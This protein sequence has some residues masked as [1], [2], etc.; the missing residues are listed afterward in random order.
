MWYYALSSLLW[1]FWR[2]PFL[3][4]L[5]LALA[6]LLIDRRYIGLLPDLTRPFRHRRH[7]ARLAE[8]IRL[9]PADAGSQLELG[10]LHLERGEVRQ[11]LPLLEQALLRME[12]S[13]R[14]HSLLGIAY[15]RL[16]RLPEAR[17]ALERAVAL[18]PKVGYGTPYLHL[19]TLHLRDQPRDETVLSEIQ[20]RILT[21]GSPEVFY[22]AGRALLTGGDRTGARVMFQEAIENYQASPKGFRRAHR[23]WALASR[24][25]LR[26]RGM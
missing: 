23:R 24:A 19:L 12:D 18:N 15:H 5:F 17:Q 4:L 8:I 22:R 6:Y 14:V 1:Y 3:V 20:A 13:A 10:A 26:M 7:M 21:Y 2:N 11:A 9:N 16:D 25:M